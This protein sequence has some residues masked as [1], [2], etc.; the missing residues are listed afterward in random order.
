MKKISQ[1]SDNLL[2]Q[3]RW[4]WTAVWQNNQTTTDLL[5]PDVFGPM[6]RAKMGT[7]MQ[8]YLDT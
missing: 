5:N 2:H 8:K 3:G 6:R 7:K 1:N 4:D